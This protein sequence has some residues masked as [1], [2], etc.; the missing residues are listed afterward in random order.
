MAFSFFSINNN[1]L[2]DINFS[3]EIEICFGAVLM[4]RVRFQDQAIILKTKKRITPAGLS[5]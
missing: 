4:I 1:L 2:S 5:V 3:G